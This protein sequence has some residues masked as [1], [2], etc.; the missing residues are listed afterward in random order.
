MKK[1]V[2]LFVVLF[3]VNSLHAAPN[4]LVEVFGDAQIEPYADTWDIYFNLK[5]KDKNR[6][7]VNN[8]YN[9]TIRD[10]RAAFGALGI[11]KDKILTGSIYSS[12]WKEWRK[13]SY[14]VLGWKM[15]HAMNVHIEDITLSGK[16]LSALSK[17]NH[18]S[19]SNINYG[20]KK[21]TKRTNTN[22]LYKVAYQHAMLKVN[23]ILK[24]MKKRLSKVTYISEDLNSPSPRFGV[25]ETMSGTK[26]YSSS[27]RSANIELSQ[28]RI[29]LELKLKLQAVYK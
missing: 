10:I 18:V 26:S 15:N 27:S 11:K 8:I 20:L 28:K 25:M 7:S 13:D 17:I 9:Q 22:K 2:T 6:S 23:A 5:V 12:E 16:V 21:S 4:N 19:I 3:L 1:L 29:P 24:A 14:T